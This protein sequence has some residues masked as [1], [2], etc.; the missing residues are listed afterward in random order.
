MT[1][2]NMPELGIKG[3]F[4]H[5]DTTPPANL[6]APAGGVMSMEAT[7]EVRDCQMRHLRPF[8][9]ACVRIPATIAPQSQIVCQAMF[10][11]FEK[12][13]KV[14]EGLIG[15]WI[16]GLAQVG[17][18]EEVTF[19]GLSILEKFG[20]VKFQAPDNAYVEINSTKAAKAWV[21]F[22]PK[23]MEMIYTEA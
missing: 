6:R 11:C 19:V 21:R 18:P 23:F 13:G 7:V 9:M 4:K 8:S 14:Q 20:Y 5:L 16:W 15:D 10:S 2:L 12:S 17:I 3:E 1:E 22:Q